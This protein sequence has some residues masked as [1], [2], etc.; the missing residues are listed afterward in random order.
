[1]GRTGTF[2][3]LLAF[4]GLGAVLAACSAIN[5]DIEV[6]DDTVV[7]SQLSTVNGA[8]RIGQRSTVTG[9]IANV[10]G[11]ISIGS[12]SQIGELRNV[13]GAIGLAEGT[14]AQSIETVNGAVR[15]GPGS[16]IHG[17]INSVNGAVDLGADVRVDGGLSSVNGAVRLDPGVAVQGRVGTTNGAIRLQGASV[18][19]IETRRGTVEVLDGSIVEGSLRVR[20]SESADRGGPVRVVIGREAQIRGALEFEREV[21][22]FVHD[23]ASIGEVSGAAV[24]RYSGDQP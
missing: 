1:M 22:L 19:S 23:S 4:I 16:R 9:S 2:F 15:L 21:E 17:D 13:N 14:R 20:R 8:I 3:R 7:D 12:G 24:T 18:G 10:N 11:S 5:Q 6:D